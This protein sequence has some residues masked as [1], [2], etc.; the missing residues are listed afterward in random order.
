MPARPIDQVWFAAVV[1]GLYGLI[2]LLLVQLTELEG[3]ASW[4]RLLVAPGWVALLVVFFVWAP[5]LLTHK[6]VARRDLLP[7]A[8]LTAVG[9]VVLM[10]VS[11][12]LMDF[13]V[14]LYAS[15][16]GGFGVVLAIYFWGAIGAAL[17]VGAASVS[18]SLAQRRNVR[19]G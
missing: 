10:L 14:N 6:L 5:W 9:L 2:L 11:S 19:S 3:T 13:W 4:A 12:F 15:D 1:L 17:V 16:Y 7:G 8:L 18:P